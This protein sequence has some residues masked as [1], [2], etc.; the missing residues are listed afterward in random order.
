MDN[1]FKQLL[2][3]S[4]NKTENIACLGLDP[5][6]EKEDVSIEI[7]QNKTLKLTEILES[8]D[9]QFSMFK[10]N[11][12]WWI[13]C[14]NGLKVMTKLCDII[15]DKAPLL[16]DAKTGDIGKS[17]AKWS[18][19]IK[20][21]GYNATT[22]HWALGRDSIEPYLQNGFAY[23]LCLTSNPGA[24]ETQMC[25]M[26]SGKPYYLEITAQ[27]IVSLAAKHGNIGAVVGATKLNQD[28]EFIMELLKLF[29]G[30]AIPLLFPGVGSQ[31][32]QAQDVIKA[33]KAVNYPLELAR[34]TSSS[35]IMYPQNKI[36]FEEPQTATGSI[37]QCVSAAKKFIE[38]CHI[39]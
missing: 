26:Q 6:D 37:N 5:K 39:S 29:S 23:V 2:E 12:G 19:F 15:K 9:K 30:A 25:I 21:L 20:K 13:N 31:G 27:M 16:C 11:L 14:R 18:S 7:Y 34:I 4:T 3:R 35:G 28:D 17:S 22:V 24:Q 8:Q 10:P 1:S 33:L 32:G 36:N 38:E